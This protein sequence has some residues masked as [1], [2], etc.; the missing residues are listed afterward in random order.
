MSDVDNRGIMQQGKPDI[1]TSSAPFRLEPRRSPPCGGIRTSCRWT[2]KAVEMLILL[3]EGRLSGLVEGP[4]LMRQL[5][6]DTFVEE[7]IPLA[8]GL[9]APLKH[10]AR[11]ATDGAQYIETIARGGG[12]RFA[13]PATRRVERAAR[14]DDRSVPPPPESARRRQCPPSSAF[15]VDAVRNHAAAAFLACHGDSLRPGPSPQRWESWC[16]ALD[17]ESTLRAIQR[18]R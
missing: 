1:C 10:L 17:P 8:P 12:Y 18:Q 11:R 7:A 4:T 13:I 5:W 14:R 15:P 3:V 2:P 6:P 16:S 9:Q